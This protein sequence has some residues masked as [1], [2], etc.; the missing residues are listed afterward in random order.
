MKLVAAIGAIFPNYPLGKET[1][2]GYVRSLAHTPVGDSQAIFDAVLN[3]CEYMPPPAKI[4]DLAREC[5]DRRI[6]SQQ[7]A[8]EH[9]RVERYELQTGI[10]REQAELIKTSVMQRTRDYLRRVNTAK[11]VNRGALPDGW[12]GVGPEP[13][14]YR[15]R[16]RCSACRG[17]DPRCPF[18]EGRGV[19]CPTCSGAHVLSAKRETSERPLYVGCHDCT[20]WASQKTHEWDTGGMP[21]YRR[22]RDRE[23]AAIHAARARR[24]A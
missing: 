18:C 5:A 10:S 3:A 17:N 13:Q 6:S 16:T 9:E 11:F 22:D 8:A 12:D 24:A 4:L 15:D 19:V 21:I 1:M 20:D 23:R 14:P 2:A 7:I